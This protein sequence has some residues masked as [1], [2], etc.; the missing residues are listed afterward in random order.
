MGAALW[1]GL[2]VGIA[3]L[4]VSYA[5]FTY[6]GVFEAED[7]GAAAALVSILAGVLADRRSG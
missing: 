6:A 7:V 1:L 3:I 2:I 4:A 5:L